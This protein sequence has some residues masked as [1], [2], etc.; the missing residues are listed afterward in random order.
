MTF[1]EL[2]IRARY[3]VYDVRDS[4]GNIITDPTKD[5]IRWTSDSLVVSAREAL[6]E[7]TRDIISFDY[8]HYFNSAYIYRNV[9]GVLKPTGIVEIDSNVIG[10]ISGIRRMMNYNKDIYD[11]V[12]PEL[13][14]S[15]D[16]ENSLLENDYV[17]SLSSDQDNNIVV[18]V[19]PLPES[20]I[21]V[22]LICYI[23]LS[24]VFSL[25]Y[26]NNLPFINIDDLMLDYIVRNCN[27]IEH[28]LDEYL[29]IDKIIEKKLTILKNRDRNELFKSN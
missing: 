19:L 12:T 27:I 5:G 11:Y 20:D 4:E 8:R 26:T 16:Y 29:K 24:T 1:S 15:K 9:P 28:D 2:I 7:L 6:M 17:F 23:D 13:F 25:V 18:N 22:K 21:N 3:R 10:K 14:Y